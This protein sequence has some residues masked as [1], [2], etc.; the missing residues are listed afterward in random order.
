MILVLKAR[1]SDIY[2]YKRYVPVG[3]TC[4]L[5]VRVCEILMLIVRTCDICVC[6]IYLSLCTCFDMYLCLWYVLVRYNCAH[7]TYLRDKLVRY[8]RCV[9][10]GTP[11]NL[12]LHTESTEHLHTKYLQDT[13]ACYC[14]T[15]DE[16]LRVAYPTDVL[17]LCNSNLPHASFMSLDLV[18][19]IIH[20]TVQYV[21]YN[22]YF[23]FRTANRTA[24]NT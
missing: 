15:H 5:K 16:V 22:L 3:Y 8:T 24:H 6:G 20:S 18:T 2:S 7:W 12:M 17:G 19:L 9:Q 1:T 4:A 10:K 11:M 13:F 14:P 23:L 21:K